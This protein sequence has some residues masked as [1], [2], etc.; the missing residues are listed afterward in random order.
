MPILVQRNSE[1]YYFE[2]G[3]ILHYL[4]MQGLIEASGTAGLESTILAGLRPP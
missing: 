2:R 4:C 3:K 1:D